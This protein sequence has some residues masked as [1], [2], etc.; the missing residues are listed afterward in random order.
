[1]SIPT[2]MHEEKGN[3]RQQFWP[4]SHI[5]YPRWPVLAEGEPKTSTAMLK[6][7]N[8]G[9]LNLKA[10]IKAQSFWERVD[11]ECE[12]AM[13]VYK[14]KRKN[15]FKE[16]TYL[17]PE[18]AKLSYKYCKYPFFKEFGRLQSKA[19]SILQEYQAKCAEY[20][21]IDP[22]LHAVNCSMRLQAFYTLWIRGIHLRCGA[23][24]HELWLPC[25]ASEPQTTPGNSNSEHW[26][27]RIWRAF[28]SQMLPESSRQS[29]RRHAGGFNLFKS[30]LCWGLV[31]ACHM[32]TLAACPTETWR[33]Q[34][35]LLV[36][37]RCF[38]CFCVNFPHPP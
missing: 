9:M 29:C 8:A 32:C 38:I 18:P 20:S 24:S 36:A 17:V 23:A 5:V 13:E 37:T 10:S 12:V 3:H 33:C 30:C 25:F 35:R 14:T 16:Y 7:L 11:Q 6:V 27:A 19:L 22:W 26:R 28:L 31:F 15:S 2:R 4:G 21:D 1:M 34:R